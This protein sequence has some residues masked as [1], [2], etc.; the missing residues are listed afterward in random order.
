MACDTAF[1]KKLFKSGYGSIVGVDEVGRGA[2]AGPVVAAAVVLDLNNLPEGIN[3]SKQLSRKQ[4]NRLVEEIRSC[5]FACSIARVE[6]E[7]IDLINIHRASLLA[8]RLAIKALRHPIDYVLIDGKFKVPDLDCPQESIIKGDSLSVSI[9]AA[10]ILA[11]VTR[12]EWMSEYDAQYPGYGFSSHVG[13]GTRTHQEAVARLGPSPIHRK[14][15]RGVCS[16]QPV[17]D[18]SI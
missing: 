12:D 5:S 14:T 10:S 4:R 2:I 15:F 18:L 11:K 16:Y 9:A 1:E 8:M 17:L 6:P 7:E 3:D 13:Y